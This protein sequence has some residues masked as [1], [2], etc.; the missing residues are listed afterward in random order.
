MCASVLFDNIEINFDLE[1]KAAVMRGELP[2]E[3]MS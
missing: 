1:K 2:M 3:S